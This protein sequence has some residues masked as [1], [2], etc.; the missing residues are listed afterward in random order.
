LDDDFDII[1]SD[2]AVAVANPKRDDG[3]ADLERTNDDDNDTDGGGVKLK[4]DDG[5][6]ADW[7]ASNNKDLLISTAQLNV[8]GFLKVAVEAAVQLYYESGLSY[9]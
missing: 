4:D 2:V 9:R 8:F 1:L 3:T 6:L 7:N 5:T